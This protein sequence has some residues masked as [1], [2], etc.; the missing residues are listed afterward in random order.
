[1]A[2][3]GASMEWL[4]WIGTAIALAGVV[5]LGWCVALAMRARRAGLPQDQMRAALQRVVALNM[6]ALAVSTLGL[7]CVVLGILLG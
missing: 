4:V 6:G 2:K 5:G 1:M 7:M 3:G